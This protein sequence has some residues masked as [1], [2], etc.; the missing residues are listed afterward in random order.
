MF[1]I[2]KWQEIYNTIR[3]HKLRTALTAFGV[4]WGIFMLVLLLGAGRGL[5]NG[6][7]GVFG[8][9][10]KNS[11]F[12]WGGKTS[13]P[14]AGIRAGKT[15]KFTNQ[16]Y[17]N[18]LND[19][20][21][22]KYLAGGTSLWGDYII[23][24]KNLNGAFRVGGDMPAINDIRGYI[25]PQGRF[26]NQLDILQKRKVA[27]IGERVKEVLFGSEEC[28]GKYIKIK[29]IYFQVVGVFVLENTGGDGRNEAEKIIIPL[30]TLQHVFNAPD[31][32]T[33]FAITPHDEYD[34]EEIERNIKSY[35][36]SRHKV[37]PDD[38]S[39]MGSWNSGRESKKI[40]GLFFGINIFVWFVSIGTIIA[41][42]VGVSNIMLIIVKERTREIGIR[43]ALGATPW[44]I[45][46]LILQESIF[47]TSAAGYMGLVGGVV[48]IETIRYLM[49]KFNISNAYFS[50]PEVDI[51]VAI[52][53]IVLLVITGALAGLFPAMRA[54]NINPVEALKD[55]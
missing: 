2:D 47:I 13:I 22:I 46:S 14:Y 5:Q 1:D 16:D 15:V 55:E 26:I 39:A 7:K 51:N 10:A 27:V 9:L 35:L 42:I 30:S 3:K 43:K 21:E 12:I 24:Y 50:N 38:K 17:V 49:Y 18:M 40:Q 8:N 34:A 28:I 11:M 41:G 44:S 31:R 20:P 53:A 32:I 25:I 33:T 23:T 4:F 45:I 19:H 6:V 48:V 54:A 37:S 52:T 36:A 29:G